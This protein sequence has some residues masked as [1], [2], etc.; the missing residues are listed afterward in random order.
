MSKHSGDTARAHRVRKQNIA[1]RMKVRELRIKL[2]LAAVPAADP[3][4]TKPPVV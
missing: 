4:K 3:V 1:R 2:A